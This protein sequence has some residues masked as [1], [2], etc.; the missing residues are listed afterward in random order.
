MQSHWPGGGS[1]RGVGSRSG[2]HDGGIVMKEGVAIT[3]GKEFTK[4]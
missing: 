4:V 1:G 3:M 2:A